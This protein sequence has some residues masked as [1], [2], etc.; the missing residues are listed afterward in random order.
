MW[1]SGPRDRQPFG[2]DDREGRD[3]ECALGQFAVE[4]GD[5]VVVVLATKPT[6]MLTPGTKVLLVYDVPSMNSTVLVTVYVPFSAYVCV[7][8]M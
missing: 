8:V 5:E 2:P 7:P 6:V 3:G 4:G 1:R